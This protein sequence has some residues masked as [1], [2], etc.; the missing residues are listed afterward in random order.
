MN[1][2]FIV[3]LD[4]DGVTHPQNCTSEQLFSCLPLIEDVLRHH[5]QAEIVI[6]SSWREP[7]NL[8]ELREFF[9]HDIAPRV[10]G[11]TPVASRSGL[12]PAATK[13]RQLECL[14][15]REENRLGQPWLAIDDTSWNF[16]VGCPNLLLTNPRTGFTE[17]EARF[18]H[19]VLQGRRL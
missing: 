15:W 7:H 2:P 9:S 5:L 8:K 6:S 12:A 13:V 11:S 1:T 10:V 19:T 18:L 14:A 3:F 4:F 17:A 16:E